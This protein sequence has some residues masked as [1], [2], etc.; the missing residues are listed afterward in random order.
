MKEDVIKV[1]GRVTETLG[2]AQ[3]RIKLNDLDSVIIATINGR[4]RKNNIKILLGDVVECEMSPY[5]LTKGR[6]TRRL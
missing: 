5:D 3:F 4:I 1:G 6:I 2:N